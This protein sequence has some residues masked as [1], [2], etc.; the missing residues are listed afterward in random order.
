MTTY[1]SK[2]R[3]PASPVD[4]YC[5]DHMIGL[6]SL[7]YLPTSAYDRAATPT[8]Y[9]ICKCEGVRFRRSKGREWTLYVIAWLQVLIPSFSPINLLIVPRTFKDDALPII[10]ERVVC[11]S[12]KYLLADDIALCDRLGLDTNADQIHH[13]N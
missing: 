12:T 2:I 8:L 6:S 11:C 10:C 1:K 3:D 9:T 4:S 7:S 5:I 13:Y